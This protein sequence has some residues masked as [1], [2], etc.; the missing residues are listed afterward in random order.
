MPT[1]RTTQIYQFGEL[2]E[3]G[4]ERAREWF[5][6]CRDSDDFE[7]VIEDA[8]RMGEILG[9]EMHTHP[10]KLMNGNTRHA[11]SVWWQ[12]AYCQS[13]GAWIE[14]SYR[15]AKGSTRIIRKE[16]PQDATLHDLADR[17]LELQKGY[18][19]QLTATVRDSD[20]GPMDLEL[21][22]PE[23]R[24]PPAGASAVPSTYD[25]LREIIRDFEHWIYTQLRT[26]DEYQRS[27]AV[28]DENIRATEYEFL[29]NGK[30]V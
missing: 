8:V 19:Y 24:V 30:R 10:V 16:A 21:D 11:P 5:R 2:D 23:S 3:K 29:E 20:R 13:D 22:Y 25:V 7:Y 12:V 18:R 26:E 6:S 28:V 4:K 17:L 27:D 9:F 15:Y 14:A 1:P